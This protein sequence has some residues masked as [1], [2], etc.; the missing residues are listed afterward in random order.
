MTPY[1]VTVTANANG[2]AVAALR[3]RAPGTRWVVSQIAVQSSSVATTT[4]QV[5]L[6]GQV[7]CATSTGNSDTAAGEPPV[8]VNASDQLQV[9]WGNADV[10]A[11]C[12]A[13]FFYDLVQN[14][15]H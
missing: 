1:P 12:V 7:V 14:A 13:T 3:S 10:G 2:I 5:Q 15:V 6:N 9:V 11:T 8:Q 4:A